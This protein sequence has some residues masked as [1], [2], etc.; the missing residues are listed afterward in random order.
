MPK[1]I[2]VD[3]ARAYAEERWPSPVVRRCVDILLDNCPTV[4]VEP[5]R[6]GEW[7]DMQE[8]DYTEGMWRCSLC[9]SDRYFAEGHPLQHEAYYCPNCGAKMD[10]GAEG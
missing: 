1:M 10:G 7:L 4:E 6:R 5:G 2:D 9:G 8:D 3:V